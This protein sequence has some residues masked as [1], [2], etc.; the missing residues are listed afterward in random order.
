MYSAGNH[1]DHAG[2]VMKG[3]TALQVAVVVEKEGGR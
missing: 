2:E 1:R 3:E